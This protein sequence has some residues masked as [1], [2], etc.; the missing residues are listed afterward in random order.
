MDPG[1]ALASC[2]RSDPRRRVGVNAL[3]ALVGPREH[4]ALSRHPQT[5]LLSAADALADTETNGALVLEWTIR[6]RGT[7]ARAASCSTA[8]T[9]SG[10]ERRS[11]ACD[12][13]VTARGPGSRAA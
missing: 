10:R 5:L 2:R 4:G 1:C 13:R 7:T 9:W 6:Q 8:V 11:H 12:A 3:E